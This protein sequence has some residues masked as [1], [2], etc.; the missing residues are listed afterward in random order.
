MHLVQEVVTED[1]E[2]NVG[3]GQLDGKGI[4]SDFFADLDVRLGFAYSFDLQEFADSMFLGNGIVLTMALPPSFLGY[5]SEVPTYP[6]DPEKAEEHFKK[7][8]EGELWEKGFDITISYNSGNETRRTVA[9]IFKANIEDLNSKFRVNV[10][11][12]DW[13]EFLTERHDNKLPVNI[14]SWGPDYADPDNFIHVFYHSQGYYG[15]RISFQDAE[16]DGYIEQARS[17]NDSEERIRLY[18]ATAHRAHELVPIIVYPTARV[19]MVTRDNIE[20][21]YY[22]PILSHYYLWKDISKN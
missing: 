9:E 1:N 13:P 8:F 14:V 4:P 2:I 19:F 22:N 12:I 5:D 10:R 16:I 11:N 20:G 17:T 18:S 7:A 6:Y 21:V 15:Q 3:S